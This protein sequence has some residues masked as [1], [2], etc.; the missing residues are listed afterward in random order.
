MGVR[1]RERAA[2]RR[3][4][5]VN[6]RGVHRGIIQRTN[7]RLLALDR[8]GRASLLGP[9]DDALMVGGR[10]DVAGRS[11][12]GRATRYAVRTRPV[13]IDQR[14]VVAERIRQSRQRR[15]GLLDRRAGLQARTASRSGSRSRRPGPAGRRTSARRRARRRSSRPGGPTGSRSCRSRGD[16]AD[17]STTTK[18]SNRDGA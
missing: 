14:E 9:F 17:A 5:S 12:R 8:A 6:A 1:R 3:K 2:R 11:A 7:D 13:A 10:R 16:P 18:P 4:L 15:P